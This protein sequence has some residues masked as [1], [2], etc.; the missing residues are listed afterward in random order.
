[1]VRSLGLGKNNHLTYASLALNP[2]YGINTIIKCGTCQ[3]VKFQLVFRS[4]NE[5]I[6]YHIFELMLPTLKQKYDKKFISITK[7]RL[8]KYIENFTTKKWK[9]SDEKFW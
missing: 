4:W 9:L 3:A 2:R 5:R 8:F 6:F 7:T 1:M